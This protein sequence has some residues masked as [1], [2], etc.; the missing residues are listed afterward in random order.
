MK[1]DNWKILKWEYRYLKNK[2][3][4]EILERKKGI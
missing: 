3:E 4:A 2:S 1:A